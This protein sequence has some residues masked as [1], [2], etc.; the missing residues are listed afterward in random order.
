MPG[1]R[2]ACGPGGTGHGRVIAMRTRHAFI[3]PALIALAAVVPLSACVWLKVPVKLQAAAVPAGLRSGESTV[4]AAARE[5]ASVEQA[6]AAAARTKA[7]EVTGRAFF[8]TKT[9]KVRVVT[10]D[11]GR[12]YAMVEVWAPGVQEAQFIVRQNGGAWVMLGYAVKLS[13]KRPAY[14]VPAGVW[15]RFFD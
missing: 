2:G 10:D 7:S 12:R 15:S 13:P 4:Q 14:G 11:G 6:A 1:S 5:E 8:T 9:R 3:V